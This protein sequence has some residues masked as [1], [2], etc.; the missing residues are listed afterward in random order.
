MAASPVALVSLF[1]ALLLPSIRADVPQIDYSQLGKV[2]IAGSFA[3]IQFYDPQYPT[4]TFDTNAS[5]FILRTPEGVLHPLASTNPGGQ[6]NALCQ[7]SASGLVYIGGS[8]ARIGQVD[9]ANIA[10]F[11]PSSR[12]LT[13]LGSGFDG[14]VTALSCVD[15]SST[16]YVGGTF[17]APVGSSAASGYGGS[18]ASWSYGSKAWSP[19]P[20][21]GLNGPVDTISP[22][23]NGASLFFGGSFRTTFANGNGVAS[24][25]TSSSPSSSSAGGTN[26]SGIGSLGSSLTPISLNAST[27][28]A[29][30]TTY[31]SGFG[32]PQYVFCPSGPDGI[33]TSWLL[34]DGSFGHFT[35]NLDTSVQAGGI[36]LGNTF[37]EGRGTRS[38]R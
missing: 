20:F 19:L 22:S 35:V 37:Y 10:Q 15:S 14:P 36:R 30:P 4:V 24:T 31:T 17:K 38:F 23:S 12:S 29:G 25:S 6:I 9:A 8:F 34:V 33:G 1:L 11:D 27:W 26:G 18:V 2:A 7:S 5:S 16:L 3:G 13:A 32:R 21:S 28:N